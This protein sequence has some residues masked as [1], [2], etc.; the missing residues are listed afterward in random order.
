MHTTSRDGFVLGSFEIGDSLQDTLH[1]CPIDGFPI[2]PRSHIALLGCDTL[3]CQE[4]EFDVV[5][6]LETL[7]EL[8]FWFLC[9]F[10]QSCKQGIRLL[11]SV[12]LVSSCNWKTC[13]PSLCTPL[14]SAPWMDRDSTDYYGRSVIWSDVQALLPERFVF[15]VVAHSDSDDPR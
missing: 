14:S 5:Q 3:I 9:H 13:V 8:D 10:A 4:P 15:F 7:V 6:L 2:C 12:L 1:S 11:H